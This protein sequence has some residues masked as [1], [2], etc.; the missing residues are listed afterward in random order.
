MTNYARI[1]SDNGNLAFY[2]PYD[3]GMLNEFKGRIPAGD[4]RW[5]ARRKC[6]LVAAGHLSALEHLCDRYDLTV[7]KKISTL[8]DAPQTVQRILRIQYIGA[9]KERDDGSISAYASVDYEWSVVFPQDVLRSWF[10]IGGMPTGSPAV[11]M[12]YYATLGIKPD[13]RP[14]EIK[15]AYR[16]MA[17]RWHPDVN[18]D[19]DA[20]TM[21]KRIAA[22]YEV[23]S[24]GQ[25]RRRYDAGLAL[26]ASITRDARLVTTPVSD[27]RPP[28]RCGWL[29][30][31]GIE[32]L[33][34]LVVSKIV[35][36]QDITD[37]HGRVLVTSWPLGADHFQ[38]NWV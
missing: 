14:D 19:P 15:P 6:W 25:K 34:R 8:Y 10:E 21:F 4:R 29:L 26:E 22:A 33:G 17:K 38:E 24:D 11:P 35:A 16:K 32:R 20:T 5:D 1:E 23:L 30:V 3:A 27:W 18:H 12:T 37:E 36:W 13:A 28:L 31:D 2:S 7:V 9:P